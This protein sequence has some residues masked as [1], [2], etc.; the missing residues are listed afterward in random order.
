MSLDVPKLLF[1][2]EP[3]NEQQKEFCIK[4]KDNFTY[5]KE[6]KYEIKA[7]QGDLF[8]IGIE[9]GNH[10]YD[11]TSAFDDSEDNM[12][13]LLDKIYKLLDEKYKEIAL[14]FNYENEEQKKY[15]NKFISNYSHEKTILW[16]MS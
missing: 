6:V 2:F 9:I 13:E 1:N 11:I 7:L 15:C 12:N 14:L 10:L 16:K 4:M 8:S 3:G 5:K